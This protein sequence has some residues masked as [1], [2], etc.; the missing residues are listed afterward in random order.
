MAGPAVERNG[1]ANLVHHL[2]RAPYFQSAPSDRATCMICCQAGIGPGG[3][4]I[5]RRAS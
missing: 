4:S 2:G 1:L 5:T 3:G